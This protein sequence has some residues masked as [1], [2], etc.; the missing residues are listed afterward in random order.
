MSQLAAAPMIEPGFQSPVD[1]A[2]HVFRLALKALAHPG[3]IVEIARPTAVPTGVLAGGL[4]RAAI[5]VA[6][7]LV[8][9]ETPV[10]LDAAAAPV[11]PHLR[12]HCNCP[13]LERPDRAAF[14]FAA[15][16]AHLPALDTLPLG[17]DAYP[18]QGATL[19]IEV[20]ALASA[21]G[22]VL[23]GPGIDGT[24]TL[25]VD[26]LPGDFWDRRAALAPLFPRGLD[27]L[28]TAGDLLVAVPRT[29]SVRRS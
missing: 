21:P 5:G 13:I 24:T 17:S 14:A 10:W 15:D 26:G 19:V 9:F 27:L 11:G 22:L 6:L 29:T 1:D 12:F 23:T 25:S 8:D 18:D 7:A 4:G 16:P 3:T 20:R 2:N 28:L